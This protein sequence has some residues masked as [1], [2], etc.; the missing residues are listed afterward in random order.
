MPS[1]SRVFEA[2][3]SA[4]ISS[5][6]ASSRPSSS[7]MRASRSSTRSVCTAALDE[8]GARGADD[9]RLALASARPS[10]MKPRFGSPI[11]A[12]S[13]VSEPAPSGVPLASHTHMRS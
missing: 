6:A 2:A 12:Q 1:S 10:T 13:N 9:C 7:R 3:P 8:H 5:F 4:A 11:S